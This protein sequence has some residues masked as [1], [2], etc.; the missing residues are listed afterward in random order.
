MLFVLGVDD[1]KCGFQVKGSQFVGF[2]L[3]LQNVPIHCCQAKR[4]VLRLP[5]PN[6]ISGLGCTFFNLL[7]QVC[8][9][10]IYVVRLMAIVASGFRVE[11][12]TL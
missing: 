5:C 9:I 7:Q 3:R 11:A 10:R 8:V 6:F 1:I 4:C 12:V 2:F